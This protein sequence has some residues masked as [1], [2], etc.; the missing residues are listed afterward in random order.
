MDTPAD[1]EQFLKVLAEELPSVVSTDKVDIM[2]KKADMT[3]EDNTTISVVPGGPGSQTTEMIDQRKQDSNIPKRQGMG[4]S[5]NTDSYSQP[6]TEMAKIAFMKGYLN[7][8]AA[9]F[10]GPMGNPG[11]LP[12][13]QMSSAQQYNEQNR[14][15]LGIGM[16]QPPQTVKT[17]DPAFQAAAEVGGA[18][19]AKPFSGVFF[20][21]F[22]SLTSFSRASVTFF[23][24][25][26][27]L[28]FFAV[29]FSASSCL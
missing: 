19:S 13:T 25:A 7:K 27:D 24:V 18:K 14:H 21:L 17:P 10:T 2:N 1:Q 26:V 6:Q 8:L 9:A 16:L 22:N 29:D 4:K 12:P 28:I 15:G 5:T 11:P 23:L 3:G 20:R